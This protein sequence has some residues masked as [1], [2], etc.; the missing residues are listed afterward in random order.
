MLSRAHNGR[1]HREACM[2]QALESERVEAADLRILQELNSAYVRAAERSDTRW[3]EENLA[4]D[5]L[6]SYNGVLMGRADFLQ[7]VGQPYAGSGPQAV[8]V[9]IRRFHDLAVI[10]AGFC[11]TKPDGRPGS[12]RY[13]DLYAR[14]H[15]RWVCIAAHF[16]RI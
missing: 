9:R 4:E 16:N 5:F 12:G 13:T 11:Y 8:D 3:Y 14:R 10:H 15:G 6:A 7:R 2:V 1:L